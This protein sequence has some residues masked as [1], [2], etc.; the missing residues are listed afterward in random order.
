MS[1]LQS[2]STC[3]AEFEQGEHLFKISDY[4]VHR[5]IGVGRY[6][7]SSVFSVGGH[8]WRLH[9]YP[10]GSAEDSKNDIVVHLELMDM[11]K[12]TDTVRPG[13]LR[14]QLVPL[15]NQA[16]FFVGGLDGQFFPAKR[17]CRAQHKRGRHRSIWLCY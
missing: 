17:I 8:E 10:D 12:N 13:I 2:A 1:I 7:E 14:S 3:D 15:D 5:G 4:S 6:I 16:V 11:D 9:Y